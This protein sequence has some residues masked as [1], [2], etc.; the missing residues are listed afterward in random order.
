MQSLS[1]CPECEQNISSRA[2]GCRCG[3]RAASQ[4][5]TPDSRFQCGF[6]FKNKRC[7]F[8]G[9]I[10]P[11]TKGTGVWY[12]KAHWLALDNLAQSIKILEESENSTHQEASD[13]KDWREKWFAL[14]GGKWC[15]QNYQIPNGNGT[16]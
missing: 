2:Y 13:E 8:I 1:R 10:S 14:C 15:P 5:K 4:E 9:R 12:C 11:S 16:N 6:V 7:R 3:W